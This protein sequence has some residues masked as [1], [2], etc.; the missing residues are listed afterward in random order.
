MEGADAEPHPLA[1]HDLVAHQGQQ[2]RD[3]QGRATSLFAKQLGRDEV[4]GRFAPAGALHEQHLLAP[5]DEGIDHVPL[6]IAEVDVGIP[7]AGPEQFEGVVAL[8]L[9][10]GRQGRIG[11]GWRRYRFGSGEKAHVLILLAANLPEWWSV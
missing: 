3:D 2:R 5:V 11:F 7:N 9:L 8:R 1:G 10:L 4:D 6:V